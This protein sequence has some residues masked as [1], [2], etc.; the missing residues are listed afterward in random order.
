MKLTETFLVKTYHGLTECKGKRINSNYAVIRPSFPKGINGT[1]IERRYNIIHIAS[2]EKIST[3]DY[4]TPE[5]AIEN[6][7]KDLQFGRNRLEK[8]GKTF[9]ELIEERTKNFNELLEQEK[10]WKFEE[11]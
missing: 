6:F 8:K 1:K 2:G 3:T 7:E 4:K 10:F 5:E 11:K 9:E